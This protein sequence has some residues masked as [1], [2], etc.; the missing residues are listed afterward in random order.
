MN[1]TLRLYDF[2]IPND[3]ATMVLVSMHSCYS[4]DILCK[5]NP[6]SLFLK[7][8]SFRLFFNVLIICYYQF[9]MLKI[10]PN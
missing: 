8:L 4:F 6:Y 5:G 9:F 1:D 10:I 2:P 3:I 7:K